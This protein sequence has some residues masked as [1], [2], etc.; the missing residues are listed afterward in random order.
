M[1]AVSKPKHNI[2]LSPKFTSAEQF[3][4]EESKGLKKLMIEQV[5]RSCK[6]G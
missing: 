1:G 2:E 5:R 3:F 6:I 4:S